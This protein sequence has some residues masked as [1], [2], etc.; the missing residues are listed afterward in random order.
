MVSGGFGSKYSKNRSTKDRGNEPKTSK[1]PGIHQYNNA[2]FH[3]AVDE[4]ILQDNKK[5][6]VEDEAHKKMYSE[7][8]NND[9]HEI[10]NMSLD[11]NK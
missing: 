10:D 11:E 2:I 9:L 1:N 4:L 3:N 8:V 6:S 7:I 5:L